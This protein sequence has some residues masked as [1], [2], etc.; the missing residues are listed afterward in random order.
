MEFGDA[1]RTNTDGGTPMPALL[2][3]RE[4]HFHI[5]S[6]HAGL[7]LYLRHL[8]PPDGI[9]PKGVALYIHGG[10]FPSALA[11]AHRFDGR[12]WRDELCAAGFH[13]WGLDFQGF[14]GSDRYPEMNEP[15][16]AHP[17]LGRAEIASR[18]IEAGVRFIRAHHD[19]PRMSLIAHSWG[20]IAAGLFAGRHPDL[21]RRLVFFGPIAGRPKNAEPVRYPAWRQVSLQDQW[22]RFTAE[23]PA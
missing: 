12:S 10:T 21:V 5:P 4:E 2:D 1:Y 15:A 16:E 14:G 6:S 11:I 9:S 13:V 18:Q 23:V 17:P 3:P 8:P 22:T 19:A 7:S 20:T